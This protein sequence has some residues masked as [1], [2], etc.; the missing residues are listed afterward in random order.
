MKKKKEEQRSCDR[1]K[2][3]GR[4]G[5]CSQRSYDRWALG[6]GGEG[7]GQPDRGR[8][9]RGGKEGG[10][11]GRG[12]KGERPGRPATLGPS[13][14]PTLGSSDPSL[15]ANQTCHPGPSGPPNIKPVGWPRA[16]KNF[17]IR[18]GPAR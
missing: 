16:L 15:L 3:D 18:P 13:G 12:G 14:P 9:G 17:K 7:Q 8:G 6:E 10:G 5:E 2:G 11:E 1:C 4:G